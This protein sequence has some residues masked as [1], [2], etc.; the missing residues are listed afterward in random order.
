[1][2]KIT[3][4]ANYKN[5][6]IVEDYNEKSQRVANTIMNSDSNCVDRILSENFSDYCLERGAGRAAHIVE[7][8]GKNFESFC[9]AHDKVSLQKQYREE[10]KQKQYDRACDRVK[11]VL[12]FYRLKCNRK[13]LMMNLL[14][15]GNPFPWSVI[16]DDEL[17]HPDFA[18]WRRNAFE[19]DLL[20]FDCTFYLNTK[21]RV[22]EWLAEFE[23]ERSEQAFVIQLLTKFSHL[24]KDDI[25][26]LW[27]LCNATLSRELVQLVLEEYDSEED[28]KPMEEFF[29]KRLGY[30]QSVID[31]MKEGLW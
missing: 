19:N 4:K 17:E 10:V 28:A 26:P 13:R 2:P 8:I 16:K 20:Y 3:R 5:D 7:C 23:S 1:M 14:A 22:L 27:S 31:R 29:V 6:E 21:A 30:R 18:T 24:F 11:R 15:E 25:T 9:S 12:Q